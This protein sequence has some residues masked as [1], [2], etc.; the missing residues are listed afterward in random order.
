MLLSD[1]EIDRLALP[2]GAFPAPT[3]T[4]DPPSEE[5]EYVRAARAQGIS[6]PIG[7]WRAQAESLNR[8]L[9][10][11][12]GRH[13]GWSARQIQAAIRALARMPSYGIF[14]G[15]TI[16]TDPLAVMCEAAKREA[17]GS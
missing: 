15:R 11:I 12:T 10:T 17:G 2:E 1:A 5:S 7:H 6:D 16:P 13:F 3:R 4:G 14:R 9:A 8:R